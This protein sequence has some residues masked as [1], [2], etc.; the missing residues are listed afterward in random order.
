MPKNLSKLFTCPLC[1]ESKKWGEM[2]KHVAYKGDS[3]HER[4]RKA[5]GLPASIDFGSLKKYEPIIRIG[6]IREF[7]Q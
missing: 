4:W 3:A 6:V 5:Q 7:P 2:V 1:G